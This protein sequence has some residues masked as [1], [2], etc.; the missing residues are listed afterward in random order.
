LDGLGLTEAAARSHAAWDIGARALACG[1]SEAFD[2]PLVL[3]CQSRLVFD[4][5]RPPDAPDAIPARSEVFDVP[6][7]VGLSYDARAARVA[8]VYRPFHATVTNACD[9]IAAQHT[10]PVFVTVH[11]FTPVYRGQSRSVEL[12]L[13]HGTD[14][15][16]ACAMLADSAETGWQCALNQPYGPKDG[17][18]H[19]IDRHATARGWVNVMIE[20]RNDLIDTPAGVATAL[21]RL[22][23]LM[24]RALASLDV[25]TGRAT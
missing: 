4:C 25:A 8:Q 21:P 5:N 24:R 3:A 9:R 23:G 1:L 16:L 19:T 18:L 7:N 22:A 20:L 10:A 6:G 2:A 12:G 13:L 11:S 15:R 17:V 14:D